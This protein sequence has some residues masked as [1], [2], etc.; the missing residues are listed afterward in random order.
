MRLLGGS[1]S[2]KASSTDGFSLKFNAQKVSISYCKILIKSNVEFRAE[3]VQASK[4]FNTFYYQT[5]QAARK[6]RTGEEETWQLFR[7][8]PM[9]EVC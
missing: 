7:F 2:K 9:L 1:E 5:K 6:D 4:R 8:Y 3:L